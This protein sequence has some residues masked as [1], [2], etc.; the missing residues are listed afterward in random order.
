[1]A[2]IKVEE[3]SIEFAGN[4]AVNKNGI[5]VHTRPA[6]APPKLR[7]FCFPHAGGGATGFHS[8]NAALPPYVQVCPIL[9]PGRESRFSEPPYIRIQALL[10]D[11]AK[12]LE[13]WLDDIPYVVFGHSMGSLLAF[14]WVRRLQRDRHPLPAW[15]FLSGRRA[16]DLPGDPE[17]LHALPD[18]EFIDK[19][20]Q[21]YEGIHAQ[22]LQDRELLDFFLP[23]LRAD[24]ALVESYRFVES[25][26]LD[27]PITVFAGLNDP[28]VDWDQML[29]WKRHTRQRF[30]VQFF[31]GG[32]FYPQ[33]ALLRTISTTLSTLT[34]KNN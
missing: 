34:Q 8:W 11:M 25:E 19:L 29:A 1:M 28:S 13:P 6:T 30:A 3:R 12:Q 32:H 33:E 5:W 7:I 31:Q 9:L 27:C 18:R 2:L 20:M 22:I 17:L 15:L 23:I 14:E 10:E 4:S 21:R 26:P 16:P 24:I